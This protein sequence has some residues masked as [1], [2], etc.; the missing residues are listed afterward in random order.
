MCMCDRQAGFVP[1]SGECTVADGSVENYPL[2]WG[3]PVPAR[4][5][6][7]KPCPCAAGEGP[8]AAP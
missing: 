4:D 6:P 5:A 8:A 2:D 1:D 7:E 3:D